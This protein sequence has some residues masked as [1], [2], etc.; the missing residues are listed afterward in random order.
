MTCSKRED[1][2]YFFQK[3]NACNVNKII[4][5]SYDMCKNC[6]IPFPESYTKFK[7]L[8]VSQY[9]VFNKYPVQNVQAQLRERERILS[10][11]EQLQKSRLE[12]EE[13]RT[14]NM[15]L[16]N[17]TN[18]AWFKQQMDA[19]AAEDLQRKQSWNAERVLLEEKIQVQE[20]TRQERL[21]QLSRLEENTKRFLEEQRLIKEA[22]MRKI[23]EDLDRRIY[24]EQMEMQNLVEEE[25][26]RRI[27]LETKHRMDEMN[28]KREMEK[29]MKQMNDEVAYQAAQRELELQKK[30]AA[31]KWEEKEDNMKRTI[32]DTQDQ[33][34]EHRADNLE[35]QS[36]LRK[37]M[38]LNKLQTEM[39]LDELEHERRIRK[40]AEEEA[41]KAKQ[42]IV[43]QQKQERLVLQEQDRQYQQIIDEENKKKRALQDEQEK[44]LENKKL[45]FLN[46]Q[47]V[48]DERLKEMQA[49]KQ[50]LE[51]DKLLNEKRLMDKKMIEKEQEKVANIINRM[52][53]SKKKVD[54][55]E[56][57]L[58]QQHLTPSEESSKENIAKPSSPTLIFASPP[59]NERFTDPPKSVAAS[60]ATPLPTMLVLPRESNSPEKPIVS[61][62]KPV[63]QQP[64]VPLQVQVPKVP[65]K[66]SF[67][68]TPSS[69]I[70]VPDLDIKKMEEASRRQV[71]ERVQKLI[72]EKERKH[73]SSVHDASSD[74]TSVRHT[75]AVQASVPKKKKLRKHRPSKTEKSSDSF[76]SD[77]LSDKKSHVRRP[78]TVTTTSYSSRQ[79]SPSLGSRRSPRKYD[80]KPPATESDART[81]IT[82]SETVISTTTPIES[83]TTSAKLKQ[84]EIIQKKFQDFIARRQSVLGERKKE[85]EEQKKMSPPHTTSSE[86]DKMQAPPKI[87]PQI[88]KDARNSKQEVRIP[89]AM[90]ADDFS[91]VLTSTESKDDDDISIGSSISISTVSSLDLNK[92]EK[93]ATAK[94]SILTSDTYSL[95]TSTTTSKFDPTTTVIRRP[96]KKESTISDLSELLSS[97]SIS[98]T[99]PLPTDDLNEST[100]SLFTESEDETASQSTVRKSVPQ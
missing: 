90:S 73:K 4:Q 28:M 87:A 80:Y 27:E 77:L 29:H 50:Q 8:P 9:P 43:I 2:E 66:A 64:Q 58:L 47:K 95:A 20:L 15:S 83:D 45:Q 32:E 35:L 38:Q 82:K 92:L 81:E 68:S 59:P 84:S 36:S 98:L 5:H 85:M 41:K 25:K 61:E 79:T 7:S 63:V 31:W 89:P 12:L 22:E 30:K 34:M 11:E 19:I 3:I 65:R 39:A 17:Q 6:T 18:N 97:T 67:Q 99:T 62:T 14:K 74:D 40:L 55:L 42:Q 88:F 26:L 86:S 93:Q 94:P 76:E 10:H 24:K 53:E 70:H 37:K 48:K 71:E 78:A 16:Q 23:N 72:A 44:L 49:A 91:W 54:Q 75:V 52:E 60:L 13:V 69:L 1:I 96:S 100:D 57:E 56:R 51:F 21:A 33:N 46:E